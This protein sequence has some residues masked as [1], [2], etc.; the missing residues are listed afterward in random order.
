MRRILISSCTV[1]AFTSL[2]AAQNNSAPKPPEPTAAQ[3]PAG[4]SGSPGLRTVEP[5]GA[6]KLNFYTVQASDIRASD[7]MGTDVYNLKNENIGEIE[8]LILDNGRNLRAV[9]VSV[10]GFLGMGERHVSLDPASVVMSKQGDSM[11]VVVNT[12]KEELKNAPAFKW[13]RNKKGK[14]ASNK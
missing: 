2:A 9:V 13:E 14:S 5:A 7:L 6:V 11:R 10:G 8:D 12:T 4:Q 1:L 3:Q